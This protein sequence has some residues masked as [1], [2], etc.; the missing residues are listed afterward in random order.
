MQNQVFHDRTWERTFTFVH[1][2]KTDVLNTGRE[3]SADLE[4]SSDFVWHWQ[5]CRGKLV[6]F[7]TPLGLL[8][9]VQSHW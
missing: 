2:V 9:T 4:R 8:P 6:D 7:E 3:R 1:Y 5:Q